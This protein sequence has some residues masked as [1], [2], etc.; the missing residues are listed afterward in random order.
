[1]LNE[2]FKF[3]H[4]YSRNQLRFWGLKCILRPLNVIVTLNML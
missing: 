3:K 1:M 2:N 4:V